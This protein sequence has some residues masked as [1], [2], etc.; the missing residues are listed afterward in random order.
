VHLP[1]KSFPRWPKDFCARCQRRLPGIGAFVVLV[2]I[3]GV[4]RA[5]ASEAMALWPKSA[6]GQEGDMSVEQDITKP[7]DS[8][9]GGKRVMRICHVSRPTLTLY[10]PA[11]DK[12]TGGAVV[13]C[14]GGGYEILSMDLEG[15]EVCQWLN[16]NGLTAVL[17]KYRVP[18]RRGLERYTAPLQDVQR[19][20]GLVRYHA[21]EWHIDPKRIGII[22]F[23]AGGHL[24]A[25]AS[26]RFA[27]R[28]YE[29]VD[30][31]DQASCRPDFAMLIYPAYLV[32]GEGPDL[33]PELT[34]TS[35]TTP[36]FLVQTEDDQLHV[37]NCLF[38]YL[39]LKRANVPAELHLFA[40]GGHAYALRDADRAV[41]SWPK[42]AEEWM[43]GLG[44]FEGKTE[45]QEGGPADRE[46]SK[47]F[48]QP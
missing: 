40:R 30:E 17:L 11:R 1:L 35:N 4:L 14:P 39:A 45:T 20:L 47:T 46:T 16:S 41:M 31:A 21:A 43:R 18:A 44:V 48:P 19:A 27:K 3:L 38:Y 33:A 15:T 8:L 26:T 28:T 10:R 42:R 2:F 25:A 6:P 22:G 34:V 12:D 37:E 24:S 7:D 23:S 5:N 9:Y 36:T 32:R 29:A 13:V